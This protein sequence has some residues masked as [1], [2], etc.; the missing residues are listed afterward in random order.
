MD[1]PISRAGGAAASF[2]LAFSV[3]AAAN[4]AQQEG[5]TVLSPSNSG[6]PGEEIRVVRHGPQGRL[7]VAARHPFW[8]EGG[9][10][11]YDFTVEAWETFAN[12]ETPVPSEF[13]NDVEYD[14][15]GVAWIAT[16]AGLVR[17]DG[18]SWTIHDP[19]NSPMSHPVVG[20]VSIAP[21]GHIWINNSTFNAGGDAIYDFDGVSTWKRYRVGEQLPWQAPWTDLSEVFV[22]SNGHVWVANDTLSGA[23]EFDGTTWTLR[24]QNRGRLDEIAEDHLGNIWLNG[25]GVGGDDAFF[26]WDGVE[27]IRYGF[28]SPTTLAA[29]PENGTVY[30]GNWHGQVLRTRDGGQTIEGFLSGLNQVFSLAP[31]PKGPDVWVGTIGAVG[32]FTDA[33]VLLRDYNTWNTGMPDYFIDSFTTDSLGHLWCASGEAGLSRFDGVRWRN[34]GAHNAGAEPYPFAGNEPMGTA[35]RDSTGTYWFGG[36]GIA[37][38][39]DA[40]GEFTGFWNW[41]N[42]PGMGVT[43]FPFFAEDMNGKVFAFSEYGT[44]FAFSPADQLWIKEPV[45][46]YAVLGLPGSESD[47]QG[48]VW[49]AAWFDIHRWDGQSW[50]KVV[51]PDPN[52]FF[53]LGGINAFSIALGDVF[54][55]A[56]DSG[57][58]RWDGSTFQLFDRP[59]YPLPAGRVTGIDVR[60]DGRIGLA[61]AD[62]ASASGVVVIDG[63]PFDPANWAVHPYGQTPLPHWQLTRV[64]FDSAGRLWV[65]AVS[66]GAAIYGTV[67]PEPRTY[68]SAKTNSCGALP[69][70]TSRG[71]PS[72]IAAH[73][74][75]VTAS[76]TRAGKSGLMLYGGGGQASTPFGGGTLC[77]DPAGLRRSVAVADASGTP[78]LCDG[79]LS[80][81]MNAFARG[82]LGGSPSLILAQPGQQVNCQFWGR[83][84]VANGALLSDGLEYF[85]GL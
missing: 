57:V 33:G 50:T 12:W 7:W 84:T 22:A 56:T 5:W 70:I 27:S 59:T 54:W 45:Q 79:V 65:S 16:S 30:F 51:L 41:Q 38:W 42:N 4:A 17:F 20:D 11:I 10:G 8:G 23:A 34:W 48:N 24:M 15:A 35:F 21:N 78:G 58:V 43:L 77:V 1:W 49:I 37:R 83:D 31:D 82:S 55:F 75:R 14:Q 68:C 36:N 39:D 63:D 3:D 13:V 85:V 28:A 44:T 47:S 9:L 64:A 53:D 2:L 40:T 74:F 73:G 46:P 60:S 69:S 80:I 72:A 26:R 81:D 62:N 29:D 61:A 76:G 19:S 67:T 71:V 25:H 6:I 18:Q 52:Y 32:H 66:E